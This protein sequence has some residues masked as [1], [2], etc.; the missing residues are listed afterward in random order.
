MDKKID[1]I[2]KLANKAYKNGDIPVG[3]AI[4]I[5]DKLIS[6]AYNKKYKDHD[7]TAHAEI[8]AIRKACKKLKTTHLDECTLY[9]TLEPCKMC[10]SAI[11]QSHIKTVVFCAKSPKYGNLLSNSNKKIQ[12]LE[13]ENTN[14]INSLKSF[15]ENKR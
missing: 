7:S 11:E 9:V 14:Y 5:N 6:S 8:I 12:I 13:F 3:A 15:F 10:T 4:Y 2:L 1:Y